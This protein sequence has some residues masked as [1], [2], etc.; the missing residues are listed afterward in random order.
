VATFFRRS[1]AGKRNSR[2]KGNLVFNFSSVPNS[3]VLT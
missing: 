3:F 1:A 2:R